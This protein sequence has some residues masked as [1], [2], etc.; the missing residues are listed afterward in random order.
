MKLGILKETKIPFDRRVPFSPAQLSVLQE[1]FPELE[2][3]VQEGS[4]RCF[5][6]DEYTRAG[7]NIVRE[8]ASSDILMGVKEVEIDALVPSGTYLFFSHTAKKQPYNRNLLREIAN[9][10]IT[11]IDYEYLTDENDI[12]L[13]AFGR[14]AGIIGAYNGLRAYGERFRSFLLTPAH[15]CFD[16]EAMK[17]ELEKVLLPALKILVTGGGRVAHG[18]METLGSLNLREVSPDEFLETSFGEPVLCRID[19]WDY[20]KRK[21]GTE[22]DLQHFFDHP[23]MYESTFYPYT[24]VT[25]ILMACHYWDPQSPVFMTKSDMREPGFKISVIADISC[26]INGPVPSTIRASSIESP[27]YGYDPLTEQEIP[28]FELRGITVMAVDNL[29]GELPRDASVDFGKQ[30][31]E[32]V[33]PALLGNDVDGIIERA[34]IVKDGKLT[35]SFKYLQGYLDGEE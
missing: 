9:R 8:P 16:F 4:D 25:D 20:V 12:R 15:S 1:Q 21:D 3:V 18:A 32:R 14:W 2:I 27:V 29:P 10:K 7:I 23:D 13:V 6:D 28:P 33:M 26:D 30:L 11:L 5:T 24:K 34:T 22:F 35:K 31:T 17:K 19:P